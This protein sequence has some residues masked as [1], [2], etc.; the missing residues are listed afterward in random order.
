MQISI[1]DNFPDIMRQVNGMTE[2]L[3]ARV[4]AGAVNKTLDQAKTQMV[5]EIAG[6]YS[7]KAGEVRQELAVV[8]ASYRA[9]NIVLSGVL[10]AKGKRSRNI[11]RFIER[12][13]SLAE[14]RRRKSAGTQRELR[15][16][17]KRGGGKE[18]LPGAFIG[19]KGRT[20][21]RRI[22]GSVA[23]SRAKYAGTQHAE[24]IEAISTIYVPSMFNAK[25]INL[26]VQRA[27]V[28]RFPAIFEREARYILARF[29]A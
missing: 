15:F 11:I 2:Q 29:G 12:V 7:L 6:E 22:P 9:G 23:P 24:A 28:E 26:A 10:Q 16:H 17:I 4:M 19:N 3:R 27:I 14:G 1:K 5:R 8:R 25:R 21:F 20:V 13:V 18:S